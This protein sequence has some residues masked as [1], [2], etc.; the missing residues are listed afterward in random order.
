MILAWKTLLLVG[1]ITPKKEGIKMRKL[2]GLVIVTMLAV[3]L[4]GCGEKESKIQS[5][6]IQV[7]PIEMETILVENIETENI[8]VETIETR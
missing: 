5:S 1:I 8:L 6:G 4:V 7:K 2:K 3:M